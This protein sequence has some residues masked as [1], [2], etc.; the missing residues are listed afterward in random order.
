[1]YYASSSQLRDWILSFFA[2]ESIHLGNV[3]NTSDLDKPISSA[4]QTQLNNK[5]DKFDP[6]VRSINNTTGDI[7]IDKSFIGLNQVDNTSDVD[8]PISRLTKEQLDTK[9]ALSV[10]NTFSINTNNA[11]N[12]KINS[13]LI[14]VPGGI[15]LLDNNKK[16]P[17]NNI[18]TLTR[19]VVESSLSADSFSI[20]VNI[21]LKGDINGVATISGKDRDVFLDTSL[22][23]NTSIVEGVYGSTTES[24]IITVDNKGRIS[25]IKSLPINSATVTSQGLVKLNDT[26][27]STSVT[28]AATARVVKQVYDFVF[29]VSKTYVKN[30]SKGTPNGVASLDETGTIPKNQIPLLTDI[31]ALKLSNV[32][33]LSLTG[34]GSWSV[35]FD[36]STNVSSHFN[37]KDT[38]LNSAGTYGTEYTTLRLTLDK[39]GRVVLAEPLGIKVPFSQVE[40]L[41]TSVVDH[42]IK[43]VYT[44][45]DIDAII[46]NLNIIPVGTVITAYRDDVMPGWLKLD[47]T[48]YLKSMYPALAQVLALNPD[49]LDT[50]T[51]FYLKDV[52]GLFPRFLDTRS[53]ID[54][55]RTVGS[56]QLDMFKAH[57]HE[58]KEGSYHPNVTGIGDIITSGD[59]YTRVVAYKSKSSTVGG[60]ETRPKNIALCAYIKT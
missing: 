58:I 38:L 60:E 28:E 23:T 24:P 8:K 48:S 59:D 36:G 16:I 12:T 37:L 9:V 31:T 21:H 14:G 50:D 42:N 32:R 30:S 51:H 39:Q 53:K 56:I 20:P 22:Q 3:D 47:G 43:D 13:S 45:A 54:P 17:L 11:L 49:P 33:E 18:P 19:N 35:M 52:G 34:D 1:M 27:T 4:T 44:K 5:L 2:K 29:D 10:F 25:A 7:A 26:L 57:D 46:A 41:P 6:Y 40:Q 55:S 15:A